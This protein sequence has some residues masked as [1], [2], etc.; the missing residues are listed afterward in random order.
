MMM[1]RQFLFLIIF[2]AVFSEAGAQYNSLL[3]KISGNGLD[4]A[5]YLYGTIHIKDKRAFQFGDSVMPAFNAC[6]SFAGEILLDAGNQSK[7]MGMVFMS[8]DT[9]LNMLLSKQDYKLV[10]SYAEKKL[11]VVSSMVD[12]IK[13]MFTASMISE[14]DIKQDKTVTLDEY[15]QTLAAERKMNVKGIETMEEQIAAIDKIPLKEQA[16][17]L[18]EGMKEEKTDNSSVER[19]IRLYAAQDLDSV[20]IMINEYDS[21]E[22]FNSALVLERNKI[23][24]QRIGVMVKSESVFIGVGAAHLPGTNGVIELLRQQGFILSPVYSKGS[25]Q[26]P[27][28]AY[29]VQEPA[30]G[31][32]F[33]YEG[34]NCFNVMMPGIPTMRYDT[35]KTASERI[36]TA[37]CLDTA[38]AQLFV[39]NS[40]KAPGKTLEKKKDEYF[41]GLI[42]KLTKDKNSKLIYKKKIQTA[43]GEAMEA[44]VKMMLGQILRIRVYTRDDK[45]VQ[46]MTGGTKKVVESDR[47]E[48]FFNSFSFI[49]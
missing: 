26:A 38:S 1:I 5:S 3:W 33:L 34:D 8:G 42:S 16:K 23:M 40:F 2:S 27:S 47:A 36:V 32:W 11:G 31:S 9:T 24:A 20:A 17:L 6:K 18:V 44:E 39:V 19:M 10:K 30:K 21:S 13:P 22:T 46:L 43:S 4:K 37:T 14:L 7:L 29:E 28:L 15:F 41:D 45:A 49:K 12:R 35:L 25:S 48:K